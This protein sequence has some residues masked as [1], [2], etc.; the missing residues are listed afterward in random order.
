MT[1]WSID[2]DSEGEKI[3]GSGYDARKQ[4]RLSKIFP[5]P[6]FDMRVLNLFIF[7]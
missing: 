3:S 7:K 4:A 5:P 1:L 6:K 2:Y